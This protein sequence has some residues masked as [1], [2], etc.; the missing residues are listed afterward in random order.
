MSTILYSLVYTFMYTA[1]KAM[2]TM[3][4]LN[5]N[6]NISQLFTAC[7][8]FWK[9]GQTQYVFLYIFCVEHKIGFCKG[10]A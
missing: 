3:I 8:K 7:V 6:K 1:I 4:T 10:V 5:Q 2:V 9:L